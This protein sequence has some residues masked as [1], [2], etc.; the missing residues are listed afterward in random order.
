MV[1]IFHLS[2]VMIAVY[3]N[4]LTDHIPGYRHLDV[5]QETRAG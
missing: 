1:F 2:V 4:F 3:V 5:Y